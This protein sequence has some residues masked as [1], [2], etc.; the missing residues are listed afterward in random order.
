MTEEIEGKEKRTSPKIK[1][2]NKP[3]IPVDREFSRVCL[4]DGQPVFLSTASSSSRICRIVSVWAR[5]KTHSKDQS[6]LTNRPGASGKRCV[7]S[8][9]DDAPLTRDASQCFASTASIS[10]YGWVDELCKERKDTVPDKNTIKFNLPPAEFTLPLRPR[11][12]K[13]NRR[14]VLPDSLQAVAVVLPSMY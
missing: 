5:L 13:S 3:F 8:I 6:W 4:A 10:A 11:V 12:T 7:T 2:C 9:S 14:K 1:Y